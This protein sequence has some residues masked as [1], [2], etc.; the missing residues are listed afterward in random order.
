MEK[1]FNAWHKKKKD[2]HFNKKAPFFHERD[3][4]WCSLGV[5]IGQEQNGKNNNFERPVLVLKK[6][7]NDILWTIPMSSA[8]KDDEYYFPIIN[9]G[10]TY[11]LVISQLRLISSKRLLRKIRTL[12][13]GEFEE[14]KVKVVD[15]LKTE[16]RPFGRGSSEAEAIVPKV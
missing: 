4:W 12:S 11:S 15:I 13:H 6:F 8:N 5:N 3:I 16:P 9:K 1:D 7:N 10:R 2:I 14:V